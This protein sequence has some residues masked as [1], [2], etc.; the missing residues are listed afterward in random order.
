M[1]DRRRARERMEMRNFERWRKLRVD[2]GARDP[3]EEGNFETEPPPLYVRT[4]GLS[5]C[6]RIMAP[7][8]TR[9]VPIM[10]RTGDAW[11][12]YEE[13]RPCLREQHRHPVL[14]ALPPSQTWERGSRRYP[15][16]SHQSSIFDAA[17]KQMSRDLRYWSAEARIVPWLELNSRKKFVEKE[18]SRSRLVSPFFVF[19]F[20]IWRKGGK[21]KE[22]FR[23]NN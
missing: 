21:R 5:H 1:E 4:R 23:G 3:R 19:Y 20:C 15:L 18:S 2:S 7:L 22:A 10:S 13:K 8:Y 14:P 16:P 12:A 9:V 6:S 11:N 17:W